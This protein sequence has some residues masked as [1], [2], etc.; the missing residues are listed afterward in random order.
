MELDTVLSFFVEGVGA[1]RTHKLMQH[2]VLHLHM[3]AIVLGERVVDLVM[4]FY[5]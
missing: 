1:F 5:L 3:V 4:S 2:L